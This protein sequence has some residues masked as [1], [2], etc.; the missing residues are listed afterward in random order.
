MRIR[1]PVR[2]HIIT[3]CAGGTAGGIAVLTITSQGIDL[4]S[5]TGFALSLSIGISIGFIAFLLT[6]NRS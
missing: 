1:N 6:A 3:A 4:L 2:Q 5:L